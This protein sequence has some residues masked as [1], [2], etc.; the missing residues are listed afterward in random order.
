MMYTNPYEHLFGNIS[1]PK[2]EEAGFRELQFN[3]GKI[4]INYVIG[5]NNGPALVLI[6]AQ[7][8]TWE[9]YKKV[10]IPLSKLFQ[11]FVI[12]VRGHGKSSWTP[13]QYS[14]KTIGDD[15]KA[16]L[17]GAVKRRAFIGGN[18]SGG[19]ITLWCAANLPNLVL[20]AIIEDAPIFSV[21]MPRFKEQDRFV[22]NGLAHLVD[23]IGDPL[24]RNLADYFRGQVM[25]VSEKRKKEVPEWFIKILSKRIRKF[26][27]KHPG[28]PVEVGFPDRMR[29]YI[30][31]LSMFDPDFA[32]AFV[33]GRFYEGINHKEALKQVKCPMLIMHATWHRYPEFGLVGAMDDNDAKHIFEL[34]PDAKYVKTPANHVIHSFKPKEYIRAVINFTADI[35]ESGKYLF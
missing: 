10:M 19:I 25:P 21:E 28:Q 27:T 1:D 7:I 22:Y 3:T 15:M 30:K 35:K 16:F 12:D 23:T 5:P 2:I 6:P 32:R 9:T 17:E 33:D 31:S 24:N 34:V 11:I 4:N 26:E 8:G 13:G 18:S 29:S 14:W 20:G